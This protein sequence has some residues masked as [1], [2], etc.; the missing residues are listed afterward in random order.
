MSPRDDEPTTPD[1][2]EPHPRGGDRVT[3]GPSAG[4]APKRASKR[5]ECVAR[6]PADHV[7]RRVGPDIE[8]RHRTSGWRRPSPSG[9]TCRRGTARELSTPRSGSNSLAISPTH[10]GLIFSSTHCGVA[11]GHPIA[12]CGGS[13]PGPEG[14]TTPRSSAVA[15]HHRWWRVRPTRELRTPQ[16][17]IRPPS[18]GP[19]LHDRSQRRCRSDR[20]PITTTTRGHARARYR[21]TRRDGCGH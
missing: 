21:R 18:I 1:S 7:L 2:P 15:W 5:F 20:L 17:E 8:H 6:A 9:R 10:I 4:L 11:A 19:P 16:R 14:R 3:P 13:E 12:N